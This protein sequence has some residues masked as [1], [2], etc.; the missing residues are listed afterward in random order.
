M[1]IEICSIEDAEKLAS[2]NKRLIGDEKSTNEMAPG[3]LE[4][5]MR[6]F[7]ATAYKAYWFIESGEKVGYALIDFSRNP[8]YLRQF[9]IDRIYRKKHLGTEAFQGLLNF[10]ETDDIDIEVLSWNETGIL[11]WKSL[12]FKE[13]S[14]YMRHE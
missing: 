5:R 11:F 14:R 3:E 1:E 12:R 8:L 6:N 7:L 10:L 9:Y 13:L 4:K 2:M